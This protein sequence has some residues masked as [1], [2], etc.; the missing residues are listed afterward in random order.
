MPQLWTAQRAAWHIATRLPRRPL[1]INFP[2]L[3]T[4]VLRLLGALPARLRLALGQRLARHEQ[5]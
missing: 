1:E 3:F 4:L 5:E 2:G